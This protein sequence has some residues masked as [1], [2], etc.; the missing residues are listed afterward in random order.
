MLGLGIAGCGLV[1]P[2]ARLEGAA[3]GSYS[4]ARALLPSTAVA[5]RPYGDRFRSDP[6]CYSGHLPA[7]QPGPVVLAAADNDPRAYL[8]TMAAMRQRRHAS[9]A[10]ARDPYQASLNPAVYLA[11]DGTP[12]AADGSPTS[13]PHGQL[14]RF[15]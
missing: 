1:G 9:A 12:S 5:P 8:S 10:T 15:P 6:A 2:E 13:L 11:G 3:E 7:S 4:P 14:C